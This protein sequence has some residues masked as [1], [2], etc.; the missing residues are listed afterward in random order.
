[1]TTREIVIDLMRKTVEVI[2]K[3][4]NPDRLADIAAEAI[5]RIDTRE[6]V[7]I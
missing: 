2:R 7:D 5:V 1:M 6:E 4:D 3:G